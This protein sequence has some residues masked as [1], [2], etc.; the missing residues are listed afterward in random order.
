MKEYNFVVRLSGV[1]SAENAK[2]AEEKVNKHLDDLGAVESGDVCWPDADI[3]LDYNG[4]N[5]T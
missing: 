1:V 4:E 3:E 2:E 5:L